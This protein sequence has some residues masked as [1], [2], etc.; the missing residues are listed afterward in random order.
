M[1][2]YQI[3][4]DTNVIV[5]ALRSKRGASAK[6]LRLLGSDKFDINISAKLILEYEDVLKRERFSERWSPDDADALLDYVSLVGKKHQIWFLWRPFLPDAKDD[7]ILELAIKANADYIIA[8]NLDDFRNIEEFGARAI[9]P[10][11]FL[12]LIGEYDERNH[13]ENS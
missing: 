4:L 12:Q 11:A 2:T 10:K 7:F 3:V 9:A 6:L 13:R 8:H 1:A 5:A